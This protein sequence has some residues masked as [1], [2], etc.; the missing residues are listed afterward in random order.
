VKAWRLVLLAVSATV[1]GCDSPE[2]ARTRGGGPGG[3]IGNRPQ[4][5]KMHE[6]SDPFWKTPDRIDGRHPPLDPARQARQI[7]QPSRE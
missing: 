1:A 6:G 4:M 7:S 5:V 2:A 3:D